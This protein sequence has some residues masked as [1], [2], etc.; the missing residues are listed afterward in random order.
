M[1]GKKKKTGGRIK[2]SNQQ[3][4]DL[5]Y[6]TKRETRSSSSGRRSK[7]NE[8]I[9][10]DS[11]SDEGDDSSASEV[12]AFVLLLIHWFINKKTLSSHYAYSFLIL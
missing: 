8:V 5:D 1:T 6:T 9:T 10:I 7:K 2:K 12:S 4:L 11:S 3:T